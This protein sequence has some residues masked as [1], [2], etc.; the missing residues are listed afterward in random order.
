MKNKFAFF[1]LIFILNFFSFFY[2]SALSVNNFTSY[3]QKEKHLSK[4]SLIF[5]NP[6]KAILFITKA[7]PEK[8]IKSGFDK[9]KELWFI[10]IKN[11]RKKN[12]LFWYDNCFLPEENLNELLNVTNISQKIN[13]QTETI[14]I[15]SIYEPLFYEYPETT[16]DPKN[17][18]KEKIAQIRELSSDEHIR[19][20]QPKGITFL[21][22]ALYDG[23]S[24]NLIRTNIIKSNFFGMRVNMHKDV[25][26]HLK[27]VEEKIKTLAVTNK[28]IQAFIDEIHSIGG[29]NWRDIRSSENRSSHSWGVSIDIMPVL[30]GRQIYWEWSKHSFGDKWITTSLNA[31]WIPPK[32]VIEAFESEGFI[33][34][35]KWELWDNMHFEYRPEILS[36]TFNN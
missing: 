17:F 10:T 1:Y 36:L 23:E 4:N 26:P 31:R 22:N 21:F 32:E 18:S 29:F 12:T 19:T 9:N 35:G 27:K 20:V 7:Y 14:N 5:I 13:T 24:E 28:K 33:W 25:I 34:G 6:E 15:K 2:S 3:E 11:S 16:P 8:I 30:R